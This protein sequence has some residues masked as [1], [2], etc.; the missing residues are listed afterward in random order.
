MSVQ[1]FEETF[2]CPD[3]PRLRLSNIRGSV[4]IRAGGAGK[5]SVVA[6]K[7]I[8]TGDEENTSVDL[9]QSKDGTV[10]VNTR[11]NQKGFRF[12]RNW[13]PC[14]VDYDVSVPEDCS[15][16]VRG[17]SNSAKMEGIRGNQDISSVSGGVYLRDLAGELKIKMV[18]GDV[19]AESL[20]GPV[21][22]NTVS[23]NIKISKSDITSLSA[24][25]VSGDLLVDSLLGDGPHN[26]KSVSGD[27]KLHIP[28]GQG[29]V[30]TSSS[31]SGNIRS[32]LP[33]SQSIHTRN[34]HR[35]EIE[36]GGIEINHSSVSGDIILMD[37]R[38]TGTPK[39]KEDL[40]PGEE[41]AQS[42]SEILE[43]VNQGELSVDQ[44]VEMLAGG[45]D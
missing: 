8:D 20:S 15:L 3:S 24:K 37:E 45:P 23:G 14:K 22:L 34:Q 9:S 28:G 30:V 1:T 35:I 29:A 41:P 21:R 13:V 40:L 7:H 17:V 16:K 31:L 11:Y 44:A 39:V 25:T 12:F 18:S 6:R 42:Q 26:I 32:S 36:G 10:E 2:E 19:Q 5:I 43:Q 27:V 4:T 38:R 33:C